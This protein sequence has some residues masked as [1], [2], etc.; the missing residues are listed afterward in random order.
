[1]NDGPYTKSHLG[2][3]QCGLEIHSHFRAVGMS[4]SSLQELFLP[5]YIRA[6][7]LE[8]D[9]LPVEKISSLFRRLTRQ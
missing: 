9:E 4:A 3:H 6:F 5:L 7:F 8:P 2:R 1:M